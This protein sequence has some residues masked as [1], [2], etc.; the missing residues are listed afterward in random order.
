MRVRDLKEKLSGLDD[1]MLVYHSWDYGDRLNT[2][3]AREVSE[4]EEM[5]V[6]KS[7]YFSP[8]RVV[9]EDGHDEDSD[10]MFVVLIN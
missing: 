2:E 9:V 8:L 1:D 7:T 5:M 4:I 3:V 10:R 6:E